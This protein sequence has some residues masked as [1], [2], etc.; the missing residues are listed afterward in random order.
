VS[1]TTTPGP[2]ATP[3]GA[4]Q[5]YEHDR[6][7]VQAFWADLVQYAPMID[8][9]VNFMSEYEKTESVSPTGRRN[10][11]GDP[12]QVRLSSRQH[13]KL[14]VNIPR[15]TQSPAPAGNPRINLR[16]AVLPGSLQE[17]TLLR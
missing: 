9:C 13:L 14:N 5:L 11:S 6:A 10:T 4:E 15:G 2:L 8:S 1:V 17:P 12:D 3:E 16:R 7:W